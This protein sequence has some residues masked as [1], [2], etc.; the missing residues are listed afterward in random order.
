MLASTLR[1]KE[2]FEAKKLK[3][4]DVREA[5]DG[6]GWVYV[7]FGG[8]NATAIRVVFISPDTEDDEILQLYV[9]PFCKSIPEDKLLDVYTI[10]NDCNLRYRFLKFSL[11][12]DN[13]VR[14]TWD[15]LLEHTRDVGELAYEMLYRAVNIVDDVYPS[16]MKLIWG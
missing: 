10:I 7:T 3:G 15:V 14:A 8:D 13:E 11:D 4:V 6:S 1:I 2:A 16:F 9:P 5:D 12:E